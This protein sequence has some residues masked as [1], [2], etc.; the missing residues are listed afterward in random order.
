MVEPQKSAEVQDVKDVR[1]KID[2]AIKLVETYAPTRA[3]A[4]VKTK[5]EEAKMWAGKEF[6][7][8]GRELPAE[9]RDEAKKESK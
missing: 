3:L 6:E 2:E 4:L 1:V 7:N 9:Y 8:L 5:L